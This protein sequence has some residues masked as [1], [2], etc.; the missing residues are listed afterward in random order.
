MESLALPEGAM[1]TMNATRTANTKAAPLAG[2]APHRPAL[3]SIYLPS[4]QFLL[5]KR[6]GL[7]AGTLVLAPM[8]I[9]L[10]HAK[11]NCNSVPTLI[12]YPQPCAFSTR[13]VENLRKSYWTKKHILLQSSGRQA[14][15]VVGLL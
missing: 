7:G 10:H 4:F 6:I 15:Y 13:Y 3:Y 2:N 9:R 12:G 8:Q 14:Q 5:V 11:A 1:Y